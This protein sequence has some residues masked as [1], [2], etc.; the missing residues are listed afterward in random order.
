MSGISFKEFENDIASIREYIKHIGLVNEIVKN[1]RESSDEALKEFCTHLSGFRTYKKIFEYKSIV[2][3]LYGIIEKHIN[4]WIREHTD[5]IPMLI[6]EYDK[7]PE[8]IKENNFSFS[9]KLISLIS[10]N[11]FAKYEDL[12]KE[13][14]LIKLNNCLKQSGTYSLNGEAFMPFSGNLKHSKI[15]EAFKTLNIDLPKKIKANKQFTDFYKTKYNKSIDNK[16]NEVF[17]K[18]DEIVSLRNDIAHGTQIDNILNVTEFE[19]YI[20]FL[21]KYGKAIFESIVEKEIEYEAEYLYEEIANIINIYKQGSILCFEIEGTTI[22]KGDFIIIKTSDNHYFKK[23]I[24]EIQKD[25]ITYDKLS[26]VLKTK[27]GVNLGSG[28]TKRQTFFIRL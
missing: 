7:L 9:I 19:D 26:V 20:V 5:R 27:V 15:I 6:L 3:S 23:E 18:I 16:G 10:E 14:I 8:I 28:L 13:D 17:K 22:N 21:E 1:N 25:N 11:R 12:N 24:L 4:I 2:I